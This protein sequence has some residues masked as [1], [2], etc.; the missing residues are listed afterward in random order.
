MNFLKLSGR[1]PGFVVL[2]SPLTTYK[3]GDPEPGEED[4]EVAEDMIYA[5]YQDIADNFKD[6]QVIVFENK[7]PDTAIIPQL[8]YEHFTKSRGNGRYGFFPLK[9]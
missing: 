8:N 6:S 4:K 9:N 5:F 1:H 7:E 3:E 2:D